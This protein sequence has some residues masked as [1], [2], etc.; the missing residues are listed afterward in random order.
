[1]NDVMRTVVGI[2]YGPRLTGR[3]LPPRPGGHDDSVAA[4]G[5]GGLG[6]RWYVDNL[7]R[8]DGGDGMPEGGS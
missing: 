6:D 5:G 1:M 4:A 2:V 7:V 3:D 8:G